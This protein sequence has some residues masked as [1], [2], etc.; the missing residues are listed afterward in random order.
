MDIAI[1]V[2]TCFVYNPASFLNS[3]NTESSTLAFDRAP[4]QGF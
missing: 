3:I 1:A 4:K 2:Q